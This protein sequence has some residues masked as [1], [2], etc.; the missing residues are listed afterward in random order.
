MPSQLGNASPL[1]INVKEWVASLSTTVLLHNFT[2]VKVTQPYRVGLYI[3]KKI[4]AAELNRANALL[5]KI[6]NYVNKKVLRSIYFAN[7][8]SHVN[9]SS[10]I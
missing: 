3:L 7:F 1:F 10:L 5:I 4:I 8:D 2:Q 9:F 6:R